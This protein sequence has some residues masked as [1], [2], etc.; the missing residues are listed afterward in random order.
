MSRIAAT[1]DL[2]PQRE[3]S[4]TIAV[5]ETGRGFSLP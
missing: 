5:I 4:P 1:S 3:T 2:A